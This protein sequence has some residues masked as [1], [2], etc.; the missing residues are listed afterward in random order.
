[1]YGFELVHKLP[2]T[3]F[4]VRTVLGYYSRFLLFVFGLKLTAQSSL[5]ADFLMD[6]VSYKYA[7]LDIFSR[8]VYSPEVV[9][10]D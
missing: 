10:Y 4:S 5:D 2:T 7:N 9:D 8:S 1:M 3:K 6:R